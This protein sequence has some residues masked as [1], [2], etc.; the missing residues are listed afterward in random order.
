MNILRFSVLGLLVI[1]LGCSKAPEALSAESTEPAPSEAV[2]SEPVKSAQAH[3]PEFRGP[4]GNGSAVDAEN[5]PL[6]WS[7]EEQVAWK[8]AIPH[9]GWSSPVVLGDQIWLTTA[10]ED[11]SDYYV[12]QVNAVTGEVELNEALF[13]SDNP[14]P[15]GN[16]VNCYASP[17]PIV[18]ADRVYVHFGSYGT[19]C[20]DANTKEVLW[21]R[22]DL[23]CLH[24]RGPGS[25]PVLFEDLLILSFDGID[26]QYLTAL[27]KDTGETVWRTDRTTEWQDLDE[28]GKPKRNGDFRKAFST[29]LIVESNGSPLMINCGSYTT[30]AHDPRTGKEIWKASNGGFTPQAR[31]VF[32]DGVVYVTT[33]YA[34][35]ELLAIR[36]DGEGDVTDSHVA[37][38]NDAKTLPSMTSPLL[39]DGLLYLVNN[40]GGTVTC[41]DSATGEEVWTERLGG[42]FVASPLYAAGRLYFPSATGMTTVMKAGRTAEILAEN[43]LDEGF[44]ASPAMVGSSL[45]LR[46]KTH[47]YRIDPEN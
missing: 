46:T 44:M 39:V 28:E 11:G 20:L 18:E 29:P 41:L 13:H 26:V 31:P 34:P 15:L 3:W 45:I 8:T 47:L 32:R 42:N 24:F 16:D 10:T 2:S 23:E 17:S 35:T 25:S 9:I 27:N 33:G 38:R 14:E 6:H 5:A 7:E 21:R 19:A 12:I 22:E 1:A 40:K 4:L 43:R 30:Y 36:V 37:W